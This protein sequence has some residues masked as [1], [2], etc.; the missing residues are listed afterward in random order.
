[1]KRDRI[2]CKNF[3]FSLLELL[4]TMVIIAILFLAMNSHQ[5]QVNQDKQSIACQANLRNIH[6]ALE[7]YAAENRGRLPYVQGATSSDEP[8]SLL[9]PRSTSMTEVFICPGSG[10]SKLPAGKPFGGYVISYAYA[11]GLQIT[12]D[13]SSMLLSDGQVNDQPK[14]AGETVFSITGRRP[15][16][17][18]FKYGGNVLFAD[19][20][21][22]R[23]K[24]VTTNDLAILSGAIFLNPRKR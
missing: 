18:H 14:K 24:P 5:S 23:F 9:V 10:D 8:L 3:G 20:H 12:N 13:A 15:G 4:L 16:A 6:L 19:G 21:V 1:M 7:V 11:M 17:N 22:E 2:F